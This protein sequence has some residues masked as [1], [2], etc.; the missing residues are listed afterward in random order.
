M[1]KKAMLI[2]DYNKI[3]LRHYL[4]DTGIVS[5][6]LTF[7]SPISYLVVVIYL[8]FS[9]LCCQIINVIIRVYV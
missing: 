3:I 6:Y 9:R 4:N 8:C 5:P 2:S 1:P 7:S